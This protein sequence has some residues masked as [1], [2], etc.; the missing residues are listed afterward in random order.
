V[1]LAFEAMQ[2]PVSSVLG[3]VKV[4]VVDDD[5]DAAVQDGECCCWWR[6][7]CLSR[8]VVREW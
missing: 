3:W 7:V 2:C 4:V 6:V 8:P 1:F 5:V